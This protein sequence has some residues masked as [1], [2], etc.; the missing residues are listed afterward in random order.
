MPSRRLI[1]RVLTSKSLFFFVHQNFV[2]IGPGNKAAGVRA[3]KSLQT[4]KKLAQELRVSIQRCK[5]EGAIGNHVERLTSAVAPN[6]AVSAHNDDIN[7]H[8]QTMVEMTAAI[9]TQMHPNSTSEHPTSTSDKP[10]T[11]SE[12]HSHSHIGSDTDVMFPGHSPRSN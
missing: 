7:M 9:M 12:H 3:R 1:T 4:L 2:F 10:T 5:S 11:S 8:A 6:V